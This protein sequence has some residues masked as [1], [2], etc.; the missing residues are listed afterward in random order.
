MKAKKYSFK[1]LNKILSKDFKNDK[2]IFILNL[3]LINFP[4][5]IKKSKKELS[6]HLKYF[7]ATLKSFIFILFNSDAYFFN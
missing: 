1:F 5:I 6:T 2:G 3:S 7:F 4:K